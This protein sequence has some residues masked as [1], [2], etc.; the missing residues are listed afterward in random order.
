MRFFGK[1]R[2]CLSYPKR[3]YE[4]KESTLRVDSL[5]QDPK[6]V[7]SVS[8]ILLATPRK[9]N[10]EPLWQVFKLIKSEEYIQKRFYEL[11]IRVVVPIH[12][13]ADCKLLRDTYMYLEYTLKYRPHLSGENGYFFTP[14][15]VFN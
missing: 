9:N 3:V 6:R 10:H 5:D 1:K 8:G 13:S 7:H 14:D 12:Q 2:F 4:S 11:L 15:Y